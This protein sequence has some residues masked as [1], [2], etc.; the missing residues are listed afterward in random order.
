MAWL[1]TITAPI[2]WIWGSAST[3]KSSNLD[4]QSRKNFQDI[5]DQGSAKKISSEL[6]EKIH[7]QLESKPTNIP[8]WNDNISSLTTTLNALTNS[9]MSFGEPIL[10]SVPAWRSLVISKMK[11]LFLVN[12]NVEAFNPQH[13]KAN[14]SIR[15]ITP[16][17]S[18]EVIGKKYFIEPNIPFDQQKELVVLV[19]GARSTGNIF[20]NAVEDLIAQGHS[21]LVGDMVGFGANKNIELTNQN[22]IRDIVGMIREASSLRSGEQISLVGHSLGTATIVAGLKELFKDEQK[23]LNSHES[24]TK[25]N[26]V[27]LI[28]AWDK[29]AKV[30]EDL[31]VQDPGNKGQTKLQKIIDREIGQHGEDVE[32]ILRQKLND[33]ASSIESVLGQEFNTFDNLEEL[34]ELNSTRPNDLKIQ[35]FKFIHGKKDE[36][37]GYQR[38]IELDQL[39]KSKKVN[40]V[41]VLDEHGTHFDQRINGKSTL[42]SALILNSLVNPVNRNVIPEIENFAETLLNE[43]ESSPDSVYEKLQ[44]DKTALPRYRSLANFIKSQLA[45]ER[46]TVIT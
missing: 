33:P 31:L 24:L 28:S 23:L 15:E 38:S 40:S 45:K 46:Y 1:N 18:S 34:L 4:L 20:E 32:K 17:Q 22:L 36:F 19:H 16:Q 29:L 27:V 26:K 30:A 11:H 2:N 12:P 44:Q 42:P 39:A 5:K 25:I 6:K 3:A 7:Q 37:V 14:C 10:N 9:L 8:S 41:H 35:E 21:V 13:I 43:I